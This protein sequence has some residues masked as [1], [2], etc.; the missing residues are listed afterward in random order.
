MP[1]TLDQV[2]EALNLSVR[3][4]NQL[5]AEGTIPRIAK[6]EYDLERCMMAYIRHLQRAVASKASMNEDGEIT[7]TRNERANLLRIQIE[8]ETLDLAKAKG[9]AMSIADHYTILSSLIGET[10]ARIMSIAPRVAPHLV[11]QDSRVMIQAKIE[12]EAKVALMHLSEITPRLDQ[13]PI[14]QLERQVDTEACL[15]P[16]IPDTAPAKLAAKAKAK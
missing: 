7:T 16:L 15:L 5:A 14:A 1:A 8:R 4:V 12:A 6:G 3:R 9:E 13:L 2:A 11:G 10:K